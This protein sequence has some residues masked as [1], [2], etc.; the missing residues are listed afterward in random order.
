LREC[1]HIRR[2]AGNRGKAVM[3]VDLIEGVKANAAANWW[4]F[5]LGAAAPTEDHAV[6]RE[7]QVMLCAPLPLGGEHRPPSLGQCAPDAALHAVHRHLEVLVLAVGAH[8]RVDK[9]LDRFH[10]RALPDANPHRVIIRRAVNG[11]F[12]FRRDTLF[13][14]LCLCLLEPGRIVDVM[15]GGNVH[16]SSFLQFVVPNHRYI[17]NDRMQV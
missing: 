3:R 8:D 13:C 9:L 5:G 11:E 16:K 14:G 1:Q 6:E 15:N 7:L 2:V 4:V 10:R 12:E 17:F